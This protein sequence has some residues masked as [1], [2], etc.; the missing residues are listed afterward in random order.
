MIRETLGG[1]GETSPPSL[2]FAERK[3]IRE[4]A[5]AEAE[6]AIR[7]AREGSQRVSRGYIA[8]MDGEVTCDFCGVVDRRH[9]FAELDRDE[10]GLPADN[11]LG[12]YNSCEKCTDQRDREITHRCIEDD[13]VKGVYD[14]HD[15]SVS[16][17][18]DEED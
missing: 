18:S 5:R 1:E 12:I 6:K 14:D 2:S 10:A 11:D 15:E 16:L 9:E 8:W 4:A 3:A 13:I 7:E 17:F